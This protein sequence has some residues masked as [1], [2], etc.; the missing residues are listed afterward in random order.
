MAKTTGGD[1]LVQMF[2]DMKD[3]QAQMTETHKSM[4]KLAAAFLKMTQTWGEALGDMQDT[5]TRLSKLEAAV[6]REH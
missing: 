2:S 1:I 5:K 3:V 6:F 4:E